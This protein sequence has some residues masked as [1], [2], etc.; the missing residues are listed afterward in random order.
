MGGVCIVV[1]LVLVIRSKYLE[2]R[3]LK[4]KTDEK[5]IEMI[6]LLFNQEGV[7]TAN[8]ED[9]SDVDSDTDSVYGKSI[10][11]R[12]HK[13]KDRVTITHTSSSREDIDSV[14]SNGSGFGSVV[15]GIDDSSSVINGDSTYDSNV[16]VINEDE[17]DSSSSKDTVPLLKD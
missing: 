13:D 5:Q 11:H 17:D 10:I 12:K 7:Q 6:T 16:I 3:E 15:D 2:E 1:G 14:H 9:S 8:S 4:E